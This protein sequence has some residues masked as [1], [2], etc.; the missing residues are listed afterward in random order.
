MV[1]FS[2]GGS[3]YNQ[4]VASGK[5][6]RVGAG[7]LRECSQA[8]PGCRVF[9]TASSVVAPAKAGARTRRLTFCRGAAERTAGQKFLPRR[10]STPPT[11]VDPLASVELFSWYDTAVWTP[12]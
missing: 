9:R 1:G 7:E 8:R 4:V 5:R 2:D 11:V 3:L 10:S 6:W 12:N